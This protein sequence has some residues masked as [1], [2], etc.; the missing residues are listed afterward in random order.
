MDKKSS[1]D[2]R[3]EEEPRNHITQAKSL[4]EK[5]SIGG[6]KFEA[7]LTPILAEWILDMVV[8]GVFTDPAEAVFVFMQDQFE[9]ARHPDL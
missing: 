7:Y 2:L 8:K 5:A 3:S 4:L 9:L 6:L 1:E